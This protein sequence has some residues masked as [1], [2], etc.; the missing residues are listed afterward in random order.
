LKWKFST[1]MYV[2]IFL[3]ILFSN[4]KQLKQKQQD[5][6]PETITERINGASKKKLQGNDFFKQEKWKQSLEKYELVRRT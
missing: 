3:F 4:F 1:G 2:I 6:D 5:A